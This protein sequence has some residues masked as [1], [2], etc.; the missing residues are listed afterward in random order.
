MLAWFVVSIWHALVGLVLLVVL[1]GGAV[2]LLAKT[3]A[4]NTEHNQATCDCVDCRN[5]RNRAWAKRQDQ[6]KRQ[7]AQKYKKSAG[8]I[9]TTRELQR[10]M[11]VLSKTG[12]SFK[13]EAIVPTGAGGVRVHLWNWKANRFSKV[14]VSKDSMDLRQWKLA[15][16]W[17]RP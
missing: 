6:R 5:R 14:P 13:I 11:Y 9:L 8:Q 17:D 1:F 10:G 16:E 4:K 2:L 15:P 7:S 12:L 3:L